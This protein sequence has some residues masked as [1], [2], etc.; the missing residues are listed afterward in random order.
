MSDFF[1]NGVIATMHRLGKERIANGRD[2]RPPAPSP[3]IARN[4]MSWFIDCA[5]PHRIEPRRNMT[6][7]NR[8]MRLRP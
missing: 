6:N 5:I 3:W 4:T 2:M 7:A 8:K 1:Q